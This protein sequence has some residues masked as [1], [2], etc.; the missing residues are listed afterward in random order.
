MKKLIA[1]ISFLLYFAATS[2][3]V[4]NSHYCMKRLVSV[5]LFEYKAKVCGQCGMEMHDNPGCCHDE[6]RVVKLVQ[7][8]V[9][10]P[11]TIFEL[12]VIETPVAEVSDFL[13][14][15]LYNGK[16]EL[17]FYNHSPPL[18]SEQDTYLQLSVFR[19]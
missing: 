12:P 15:S 4:I 10:I 7:D 9:K 5:H 18:L 11:V 2:G 6:T 14:A 3:I 17:H 19:I 8:Q 1:A 16:G 13:V